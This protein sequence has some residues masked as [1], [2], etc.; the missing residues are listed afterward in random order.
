MSTRLQTFGRPI[1]YGGL[2]SCSHRY[3]VLGRYVFS[4]G[5]EREVVAGSRY[6]GRPIGM[7]VIYSACDQPRSCF[8]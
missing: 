2:R 5:G 3:R 4:N 6:S 1:L 7:C 8:D